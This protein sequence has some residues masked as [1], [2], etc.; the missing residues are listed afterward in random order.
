MYGCVLR[1]LASW[2][3]VKFRTFQFVT[4]FSQTADRVFATEWSA[5]NFYARKRRHGHGTVRFRT[6]TFARAGKIDLKSNKDEEPHVK[7]LLGRYTV[8]FLLLFGL[9]LRSY[10]QTH[11]WHSMILGMGVFAA[12]LAFTV[13]VTRRNLRLMRL[14]T[15]MDRVER[16]LRHYRR[17]PFHGFI[18]AMARHDFDTARKC[19][20]KHRDPQRRAISFASIAI[21]EKKGEEA[22]RWIAE[23]VNPEVKHYLLAL[24]ALTVRD[25]EG[26]YAARN[27]ISDEHTLLILSAEEA[28]AHDDMKT[29]QTLGQ[30]AIDLTRG[31]NR[32]ILAKSLATSTRSPNRTKYF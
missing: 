5:A 27:K 30:Q 3:G 12:L 21:A 13:I 4:H 20:A 17:R 18:Y 24:R 16:H 29:A 1:H 23:I 9:G 6:H 25:W 31:V 10:Q 14:S 11:Q 2:V 15:N 22:Q 26:Y 32:Y 28:F 8:Y 19:A 7:L